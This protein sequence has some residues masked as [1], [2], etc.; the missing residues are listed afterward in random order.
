MSFS[1]QAK[2]RVCWHM[3]KMRKLDAN[4]KFDKR[5]NFFRGRAVFKIVLLAA[6]KFRKF[7][8]I[9]QENFSWVQLS[10]SVICPHLPSP[11][12]CVTTLDPLWQR[13][14]TNGWCWWTVQVCL[15]PSFWTVPRGN[16]RWPV[17]PEGRCKPEL[18]RKTC[19]R[20]VTCLFA[21][22]PCVEI[23]S[24][25]FLGAIL[26]AIE[27]ASRELW[28]WR[29]TSSRTKSDIGKAFFD[30]NNCFFCGSFDSRLFRSSVMH[31]TFV[32]F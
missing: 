14:V 10:S 13:R 12:C 20:L 8:E 2:C 4:D 30:Q 1:S 17:E 18:T 29:A 28:G 3:E 6:K 25:C 11:N 23:T 22:T 21:K 26:R 16:S 24:W 32:Y 15:S 5:R 9:V 31:A 27:N 7:S 19:G